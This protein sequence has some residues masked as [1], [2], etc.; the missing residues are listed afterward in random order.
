MGL[1][2]G[3]VDRL[4]HGTALTSDAYGA[5]GPAARELHRSG[6]VVDLVVGTALFRS[7]LL[8]AT[9]RGHVD[10][11]RLRAAGVQL[12]GLTLATRFPDLRGTLSRF[13]FRSLG[14]PPEALRSGMATLEWL[15]G[16]VDSWCAASDGALRLLPT[17]QALQAW[18]AQPAEARPVGVFLGVQGA[19][20]LDGELANVQRLRERGVRMLALA[21]VMDNAFVGSG[22][23]RRR[24]GLSASGRE[25]IAE[26][27][28]QDVLVDL[29]HMSQTGLRASLAAVS[30][31][32]MLSHTGLLR[33]SNSRSRWSPFSPATRNVP[34]WAV[35]EVGQA[36]GVV[37]VVLSTQ[38]LGGSTIAQA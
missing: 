2:S 19:H 5:A 10:L 37:G 36:G 34:D 12:V 38:L 24:R 17:R 25:L 31:P 18:L 21:H 11:P 14:M 30:R 26:L 27:E 23:G 9:P 1:I 13:H 7:S 6:P 16:R 22:T 3:S 8:S 15:I 4:L 20:A 33:H 28:R 35:R 32:P 29:A